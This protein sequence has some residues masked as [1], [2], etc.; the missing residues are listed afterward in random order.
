MNY[1][2]VDNYRGFSE[3]FIPIKDVNFLVG[4]N[5]TGKTSILGL[6]KLLSP[7]DFWLNKEFDFRTVGFGTFK[8]L[9]SINS[10][11]KKA[12]TVGI[13]FD[14]K[15]NIDKQK[16]IVVMFMKFTEYNGIP[17]L[18]SIIR[19]ESGF[20]ISI[21][22]SEKGI[23]YKYNKKSIAFKAEEFI[24]TEFFNWLKAH[25]D[26]SSTYTP[27]ENSS[28]FLTQA[29]PLLI[30]SYIEDK[31]RLNDKNYKNQ[32]DSSIF[33]NDIAWL[34]P[35]RTKPKKTYDEFSLEFSSSGEHIPYLIKKTLDSKNESIKFKEFVNH[36]GE[37][38][39][40]FK[41]IEIKKYGE[42]TTSPFELDIVLNE[43]PLSI[44][45][46]GYGVSQAL[47]IFVEIFSRPMNSWFAIQQPEVHLHPK[48]QATLGDV[49]FNMSI[50][51]DKK[52][53]VETHSDYTID[54]FRISL[55]NSKDKVA[56]QVL[57]FERSDT[58]NKVT[59]IGINEDGNF[60]IDQPESYREFFMKEEFDLLGL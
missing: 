39:G 53:I 41:N 32:K 9:V 60:D 1:I 14:K 51:E 28:T 7:P 22:I 11:N 18:T 56:A 12:F 42:N 36:I 13:I 17:K 30:I 5:S 34:A 31:I 55:R 47:P 24:N 2:Y 25:K 26:D 6:L 23:E 15:E 48:A 40:L 27:L 21:N 44:S 3:T 20:E 58:G 52:F 50:K 49:F 45:S 59:P 46:V 8:D 38:S 57:F 37:N 35:I 10:S 33:F 16:S 43:H 54:R 29:P 4:E 19:Y